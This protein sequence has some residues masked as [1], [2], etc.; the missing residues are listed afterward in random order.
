MK[1]DIVPRLSIEVLKDLKANATGSDEYCFF[2]I[3]FTVKFDSPSAREH[4][5][6][7]YR[8][9]KA[10]FSRE[11]SGT[12]DTYYVISDAASV[13]QPLVIVESERVSHL[14]DIFSKGSNQRRFKL[15]RLNHRDNSCYAVTDSFLSDNKPTMVVEEKA[16]VILD[17]ELWNSYAEL[18]IFNSVLFHIPNHYL[19]HAGVVSW[20]DR[21]IV[22]CGASNQGKSTLTL[23][24]VQNGFKFISDEVAF[25]DLSTCE[26]SLFPRAL[27]F[28]EDTL[29]R[30]PALKGL[31]E[32]GGVK[33]LSGEDKWTV[34][35]EEICPDS[36]GKKCRVSYFIFLNGFSKVPKL[37]PISKSEALFESL[38]YSRAAD[39][40]PFEHFL[41][42]SEVVKEAECFQ[43]VL[44]DREENVRVLKELV[45]I[46]EV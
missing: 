35:I 10:D 24:L 21:G 43:L 27:G 20:E 6:N 31:D 4:Y 42:M 28:R 7:T 13:S 12:C 8:H 30:F 15:D 9:F 25:I 18:V 3:N 44:G 14:Q 11:D 46:K 37:T 5:Y 32:R 36:I 29:A 1:E 26:V 2:G 23:R 33:S 39:E 34:D 17:S 41:A 38:K 40:E 19:L 16:C 22:L 45:E